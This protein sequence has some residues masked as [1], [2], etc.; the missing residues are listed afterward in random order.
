MLFRSLKEVPGVEEDVEAHRREHCAEVQVPFLQAR[1]PDVRISVLVFGIGRLA[2]LLD[3]GSGIARAVREAGGP[4]LVLASSD[5]THYEPHEA[6]ARKDRLAIDEVIRLD[7]EGLHRVVRETPITMCGVAPS[8]AAIRA[9][10]DLGAKSARL[11]D[12][13]TS[14]DETG[15]YSSVVGYAGI[16]I[17]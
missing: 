6:A 12:Y 10:K 3:A 9:A 7:P 8:V 4:V 2:A 15:D 5:M 16:L 1:R 17:Q 14:G 13:R 11:V